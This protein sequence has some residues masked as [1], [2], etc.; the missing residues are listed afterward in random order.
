MDKPK[1]LEGEEEKDIN[2]YLYNMQSLELKKD[3]YRSYL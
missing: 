2:Y 1:Y 3:N